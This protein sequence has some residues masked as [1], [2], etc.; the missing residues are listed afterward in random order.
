MGLVES[1]DSLNS[2]AFM[3][4]AIQEAKAALHRLEV[5]VSCVI[6]ENR[7]VIASG[8][9]RSNETRNSTKHA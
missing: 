5:P 2:D 3:E 4:L 7:K 6:V 1:E 8:S 9:H